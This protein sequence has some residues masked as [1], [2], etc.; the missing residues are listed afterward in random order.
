MDRHDRAVLGAGDNH[1][2]RIAHRQN[3]HGGW[4]LRIVNNWDPSRDVMGHCAHMACS[5]N[6]GSARSSK[7]GPQTQIIIVQGAS[8]H[9]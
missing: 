9:P 5:I 1:L 6:R 8:S 4:E 2:L 7:C 3:A